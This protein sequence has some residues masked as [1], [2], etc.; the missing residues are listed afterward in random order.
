MAIHRSCYIESTSWIIDFVGKIFRGLK[1]E[2]RWILPRSIPIR[3][4]S[5]LE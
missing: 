4:L 5:R 1:S 3:E 2:K